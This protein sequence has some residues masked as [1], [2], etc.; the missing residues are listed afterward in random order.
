[1]Q[2][3]R[4]L[5][6]PA[7]DDPASPRLCASCYEDWEYVASLRALYH[8]ARGLLEHA[9]A[10][11]GRPLRVLDTETTGLEEQDEPIELAIVD[12]LTGAVLLDTRLR[13]LAPISPGA[14]A[15][16]GVSSSELQD[17]PALADIWSRVCDLLS[18]A[19]V[20]AYNA[21]FDRQMFAQ[22]AQRYGLRMPKCRWY[23][24]MEACAV[25]D[26]PEDGR[27]LPLG[28]VCAELEVR[29]APAHGARTDALAALAVVQALA[30][31]ATV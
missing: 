28:A 14:Y 18:G 9:A 24:L 1:V 16:H 31:R 22:A 27:W 12:G 8:E 3:M 6:H 17:A 13:P 7:G 26:A 21:E 19:L 30:A 15:V 29:S 4:R 11:G 5:I 23:C 25:F 10:P 2:S 20:I